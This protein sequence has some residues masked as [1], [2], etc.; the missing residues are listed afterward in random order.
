[1]R[2]KKNGRTNQTF[3]KGDGRV[4]ANIAPHSPKASVSLNAMAIDSRGRIILAG[5]RSSP[6]RLV[7]V[8]NKQNGQRDRSFGHHGIVEK[9]LDRLGGINGIAITPKDKIVAAGP[10]KKDG[11]RKWALARFGRKGGLNRSFGKHGQ[12]TVH[13]PATG[14]HEVGGVAL[15]SK[16]RIVVTG[17]PDYS[18]ARLQPNGKLNESFGHGGTTTRESGGDWSDTL[19]IDSRD[20]PVVAGGY[21]SFVVARFLG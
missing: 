15:D 11:R 13:I 9:T 2:V 17:K 1:M 6:D 8:R 10:W 4:M 5:D 12:A 18:V 21:P 16:N 3:G 20:R 19:A 7:L 14:N